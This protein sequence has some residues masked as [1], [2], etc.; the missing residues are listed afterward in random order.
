MTQL[1]KVN[2]FPY[3]SSNIESNGI[4]HDI[5]SGKPLYLKDKNKLS[6]WIGNEKNEDKKRNVLNNT[7]VNYRIEYTEIKDLIYTLPKYMLIDWDS[8]KEI[9]IDL[10]KK[11]MD[12]YRN[13]WYKNKKPKDNDLFFEKDP[14][15]GERVIINKS[16]KITLIGDIHSS[17]HS[18]LD[19]IYDLRENRYFKDNFEL[20]E[21]H[22]I[23]FLGDIVDRGPYSIELLQFIFILKNQ[24][25]NQVYIINGNHEDKE[26]Y[27]YYGLTQESKN[28]LEEHHIEL[29]RVLFFL[30]SVIYLKLGDKLYHLSHGALPDKKIY[31][32]LSNFLSS[33]KKFYMISEFDPDNSLKWGDFKI[34]DGYE[35]PKQSNYYRPQYGYNIV[36]KYCNKF[37]I[38]SLIT[39]HQDLKSLLIIP[40][41][42]RVED[43]NLLYNRPI[44]KVGE[45]KI[46]FLKHDLKNHFATSY[47][48]SEISSFDTSED[49]LSYIDIDSEVPKEYYLLCDSDNILHNY[50]LYG[51]C[52]KNRFEM[53]PEDFLALTTST[54]TISRNIKLNTYLELLY[55]S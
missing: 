19:I 28:Q 52:K 53:D 43:S 36:N 4:Y 33:N 25:F 38:S 9:I 50:D 23:I 55:Q 48:N 29:E 7:F 46:I 10:A 21:G 35:E 5:E 1:L 54:A 42:E 8:M 15:F 51:V 16:S 3:R 44:I 17:L 24:N 18:L 27:D 26:T 6:E 12:H 2:M 45:K 37:G 13:N 40:R 34:E 31:D 22:Y 32:E 41:K 49:S 39:G 11:Y 47:E 20:N 14:L 30:P